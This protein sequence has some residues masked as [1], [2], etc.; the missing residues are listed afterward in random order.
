MSKAQKLF[1]LIAYVNTRR[2]FTA[3][4]V[5]RDF[6]ISVRTA[7]RYLLEL[8]GMGVPLYTEPGK[9]GGY[10]LLSGRMLPPIIFN[11]DEALAIFFA[12]QS[13]Q[14][15]KSLP[16]EV[17]ITSASRKLFLGL[18]QDVKP[19][20]ENLKSTLV[21]WHRKRECETPLLKS[22]LQ[23]SI[24]KTPIKMKY[25]SEREISERTVY[26][27][28]VYSNDGI[29]YLPAYDYQKQG[30]RLFRADRV[31]D[32]EDAEGDF[33]TVSTTLADI[34]YEY[35]VKNPI[36]LYV[37]LSDKGVIRCKDNPYFETNI[38]HN[39][40]GIGGYIDTVIDKSDLEFTSQFFMS[41]GEDAN[42]IEPK[43][44]KEYI[45]SFAKNLL[46]HYGYRK[47]TRQSVLYP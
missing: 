16:F 12:F 45:L 46:K 6:N 47:G 5:A 22:L 32:I 4:E 7:H 36:H 43:E 17:N 44:I 31:I 8:D 28:G 18:P 37:E 15:Y 27:I 40:D 9:N 13:L 2:Q 19:E 1:D 38:Q 29:W 30:I 3:S 21:F 24:Q 11:E 33:E 25:Q 14:Y 20:V 42:V 41:L 35:R 10:R 23:K 34:L 39:A 26:P